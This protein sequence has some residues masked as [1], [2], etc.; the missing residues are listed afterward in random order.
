MPDEF[1]SPPLRISNIVHGRRKVE[2][3]VEYLLDRTGKN[4]ADYDIP[5]QIVLKRWRARKHKDYDFGGMRLSPNIWRS[6]KLVLGEDCTR[7]SKMSDSEINDSYQNIS[8]EFTTANYKKV[9]GENILK[10]I[11]GI[12]LVKFQKLM[13]RHNDP[14]RSDI[15]GTPD[16]YLWATSKAKKTIKFIR[17]VEVKRPT[18]SLKAHQK[19]EIGFLNDELNLKARVLRLKEVN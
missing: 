18:E 16:L 13:V 6:I 10:L 9:A 1:I 4:R 11:E 12:G 3:R 15:Y 2:N 14:D 17:F 8:G 7:I 19:A 5:E